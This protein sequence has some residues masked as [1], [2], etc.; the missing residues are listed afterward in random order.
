MSNPLVWTSVLAN[1]L[2]WEKNHKKLVAIDAGGTLIR[3]IFSWGFNGYT[4]QNASLED[5][6]AAS[7]AFAL[8]TT[9]GDG[10]EIPPS[11]QPPATNVASPTQRFL[12][13]EARTP[14]LVNAGDTADRFVFTDSVTSHP[15]DAQGMVLAVNIPAGQFLNVWATWWP[16]NAWDPN[17]Q[18]FLWFGARV[19]VD[20][21]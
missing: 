20:T 11:A 17:G 19:A 18:A 21:A 4:D 1:D 7:M 9:V 16:T 10:T 12:W 6:W 15:T 13:W 3:V 2:L 14:R 8:V 5:T